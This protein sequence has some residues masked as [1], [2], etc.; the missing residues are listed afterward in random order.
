VDWLVRKAGCPADSAQEP[1][2]SKA[3]T[4][5]LQLRVFRF[6]LF[7]DGAVAV[8]ALCDDG[9]DKA[10]YV[11]TG[12]ESLSQA[13]QVATIGRVIGRSLRV[14]EISPEEARR[15]LL[16]V[17]PAPGVNMLLDAWSAAAGQPAFVTST[18]EE[19]TGKPPRT[20]RDWATDNAAVFH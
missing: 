3:E 1:A 4:E 12:P 10:E 18:V 11:L 13:E 14:E 2:F 7:E 16:A 8:R 19:I 9:H 5:L 17:I 20:F 6:G 15:E